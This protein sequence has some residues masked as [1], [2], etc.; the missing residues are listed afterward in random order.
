MIQIAIVE[1]EAKER[2]K[3]R[4]YTERFARETGEAVQIRMFSDGLGLVSPYEA[5]YDVIL[6]D[7][8]MP[9]MDGI[10][11]AEKIRKKDEDVIL[12]FITNM[13]QYA[14]KGYSV[15][16]MNFILKPVTYFAFCEEMK[17]VIRRLE[18]RKDSFVV[19]KVDDGLIRLNRKDFYYAQMQNRKIVLYTSHD[20]YT[21]SGTLLK[22]EE[23][24][25]DDRCFRSH[26]GCLV[27]IRHIGRI[28][29]DTILMD[30]GVTEVPLSRH[31]KKEL[32]LRLMHEMGER[33]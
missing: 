10:A 4:E 9:H 28:R 26:S 18:N 33:M 25:A 3:L 12:I 13:V 22:L 21:M 30:D 17:Q 6:L 23:L 1:D 5:V 14:L 20:R 29:T 2:E 16:A 31:K 11:A 24:L 15:N 19:L 7:I 27:N 8:Q 32:E